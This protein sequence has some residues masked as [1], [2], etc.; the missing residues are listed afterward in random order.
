M[1][2]QLILG[3][4]FATVQFFHSPANPGVHGPAVGH[5]PFIALVQ[6][7]ER[8]VDHIVGALISAGAFCFRNAMF[9]FGLEL[10]SHGQ[11]SPRIR[12]TPAPV[13]VKATSG[14]VKRT[15]LRRID[16]LD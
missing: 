1:R 10:N 12:R 15:S 5:Q 8:P 9:L 3:N 2:V 11:F 6:H 7:F 16:G 14:T 4:S 13:N